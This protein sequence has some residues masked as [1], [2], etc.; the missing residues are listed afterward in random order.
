MP[1]PTAPELYLHEEALLLALNDS[2]G[3]AQG[4]YLPALAGAILTE[5]LLG[6]H[7]SLE[8]KTHLVTRGKRK[9]LADPVLRSCRDEIFAAQRRKPL[10]RWLGSIAHRGAGRIG[11]VNSHDGNDGVFFL[12]TCGGCRC[13]LAR[14]L[15]LVC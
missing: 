10:Q 9:R 1:D 6:E 12:I 3:T 15:S 14:C 13:N 11:G 7:V 5:L 8:G 4:T 2:R